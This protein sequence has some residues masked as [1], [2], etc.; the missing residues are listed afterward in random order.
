MT[1]TATRFCFP[2]KF[3]NAAAYADWSEIPSTADLT[4]ARQVVETTLFGTWRVVQVL[5]PL[6]QKS[7]HG[8]IVN[9]AN[10]AEL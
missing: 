3:N 6:L 7:E 8:R 9:V 5:L 2:G 1:R 4:L 10:K